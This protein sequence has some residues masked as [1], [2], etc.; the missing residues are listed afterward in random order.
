MVSGQARLQEFSNYF[1]DAVRE[2]CLRENYF[3]EVS[4]IS[5]LLC[6][7]FERS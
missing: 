4:V 3:R 1:G 6:L 5:F 2:H 7:F